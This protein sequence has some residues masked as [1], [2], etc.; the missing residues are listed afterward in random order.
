MSVDQLDLNERKAFLEWRRG[1]AE[2][3]EDE[4]LLLTPF[5]KN[6]EVWRQL[7]RV[8]ERRYA[9][10]AWCRMGRDVALHIAEKFGACMA[11][12][13]MV[14]R[15]IS[16][17]FIVSPP[18][19]PFSPFS[20]RALATWSCRLSMAAP[21]FPSAVMTW[22]TMSTRLV[23]TRRTFCLSTRPTCSQRPSARTGQSMSL[24]ANCG[25]VSVSLAGVKARPFVVNWVVKCC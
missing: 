5:E 15:L 19:P 6:L 7:W 14:A 16:Q 22:H 20:F 24:L 8:I 10:V 12:C 4:N 17:S 21:R 11:Q 13:F 3:Q 23:Q 2:L 25:D 1:L 18:H 9:W